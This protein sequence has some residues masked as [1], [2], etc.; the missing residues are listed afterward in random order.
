MRL[1]ILEKNI[2][3]LDSN[4]AHGHDKISTRMLKICGDSICKLLELIFSK[5][6]LTGVFLSESKRGNILSNN[7]KHDQQNIKNHRAIPLLL[8]C[9]MFFLKDVF[10]TKCFLT[11]KFTSRSQPSFKPGDSCINQF[12]SITHEIDKSFDHVLEARGVFFDISKAFDKIWHEGLIS[13]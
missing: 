5:A 3:N 2:Q 12:L 7:K 11:N 13:N 4:K 8:I 9:G 6:L 10:L 1:K